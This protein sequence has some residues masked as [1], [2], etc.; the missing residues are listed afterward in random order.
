MND[1]EHLIV[2]LKRVL[3]IN[4]SAC[5]LFYEVLRKLSTLGNSIVFTY[6]ER[7]PL[8]RDSLDR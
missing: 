2:D 6:A 3:T 7:L 1:I 5:R 8:L 4:E